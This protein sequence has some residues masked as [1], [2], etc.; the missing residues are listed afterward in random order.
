MLLANTAQADI[1]TGVGDVF[2]IG[3]SAACGPATCTGTAQ[4]EVSSYVPGASGQVGL[5]VFIDNTMNSPGEFL[6]GLGWNMDPVATGIAS[7]TNTGNHYF[8]Y[9]YLNT[10]FPSFHTI[11]VC[12]DQTSNNSSCGGGPA[13]HGI[14]SPGTDSFNIVLDVPGLSSSGVNLSDFALKYAGSLGSFE[15]SGT[16]APPTPAPVPEPASLTLCGT[17]LVLVVRRLRHRSS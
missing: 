7:F 17:G 1:I 10:N 3:W 2:D 6:V 9:A 8:N 5:N 12:V 15:F 14:P 11:N 4:F 16:D 13:P